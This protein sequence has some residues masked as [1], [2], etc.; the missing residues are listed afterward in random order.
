MQ[1]WKAIWPGKRIYKDGVILE[2]ALTNSAS[3]AGLS[4]ST[5]YC[6][7]LAAYDATGNRSVQSSQVC[8][9]TLNTGLPPTTST[10]WQWA[11]PLPQGN[12]LSKIIW[13]GSQ[14]V[15]V[16]GNGTILTSPDG[17]TWVIQSS[18][19]N[20]DLHGISWNGSQFVAVGGNGTIL[21]SSDGVNW[22]AQ[23]SGSS[24]VLNDIAWSSS[25]FVAVGGNG[26]IL[27]SPDG[28]SWTARSAGI[29]S[30]SYNAITWNGS[31]FVAIGG[32]GTILTSP[33]GMTWTA[34][35]SGTIND[36]HGISWNGSQFVAVGG[37]GTI[38]A[39]SDGVTLVRPKFRHSAPEW[40]RL[41][42]QPVCGRGIQ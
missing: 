15:A 23:S 24:Y 10:S 29:T 6:Y 5:E 38:L 14:F 28:V 25:Q 2:S 17:V 21:A 4:P 19:T 42:R 20:N 37:N 36:L 1:T 12:D 32:N 11:N 39:S 31:Q 9:T 3:D 16:G 41:E 22:T 8:A 34:Q 35:S 30:Y 18:G 7:A 26:V 40:Y 27:T 13:D 33:D